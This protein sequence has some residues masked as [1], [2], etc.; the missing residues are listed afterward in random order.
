MKRPREEAQ[1]WL[2]QARHNLEVA[3]SLNSQKFYSD[4]CFMSEQA[5]QVALKAFLYLKGERF[6]TAHSVAELVMMCQAHS[7]EFA[8]LLN[9]GKMLDKYYIPTRYPDA[10]APP[11]VPYKT[12]T[13]E[14]AQKALQQAENIVELVEKKIIS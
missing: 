6:V 13:S 1:R 9:A 8:P 11:A 2:D 12:Y 7:Q 14:E 3:K 4:A 10:L 5:A